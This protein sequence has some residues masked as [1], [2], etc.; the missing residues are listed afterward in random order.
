MKEKLLFTSQLNENTRIEVCRE[1]NGPEQK[2]V[3]K[4]KK[5]LLKALIVAYPFE[6]K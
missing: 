3:R 6:P 4:G 5:L 2:E 1:L